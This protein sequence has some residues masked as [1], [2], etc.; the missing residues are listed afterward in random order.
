[1]KDSEKI[2]AV[3]EAV[4]G[5]PQ[6]SAAYERL[7]KKE[8]VSIYSHASR[9]EKEG[10]K[11]NRVIVESVLSASRSETAAKEKAVAE[12]KKARAEKEQAKRAMMRTRDVSDNTTD[13]RNMRKL[14]E[15]SL[16]AVDPRVATPP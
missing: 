14:S 3:S 1:M 5:D 13:A 15:D 11:R 6:A 10:P 4:A 12:A 9:T 16:R 8:I 2:L 7:P